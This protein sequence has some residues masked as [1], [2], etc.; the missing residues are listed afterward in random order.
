MEDDLYENE[1]AYMKSLS[2]V[3]CT[4]NTRVQEQLE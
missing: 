2:L 3:N 1:M 4:T